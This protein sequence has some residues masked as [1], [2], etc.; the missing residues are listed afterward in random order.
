MRI[1]EALKKVHELK[2]L[3]GQKPPNLNDRIRQII[4][5]PNDDTF[6]SFFADFLYTGDLNETIKLHGTTEFEILLIFM[7]KTGATFKNAWYQDYYS[8]AHTDL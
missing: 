7:S 2:N 5:A 1:A 8:S 6:D 4:P 3:I